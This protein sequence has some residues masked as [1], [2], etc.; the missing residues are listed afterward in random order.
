[1]E[2]QGLGFGKEPSN[3]VYVVAAEPDVREEA[4]NLVRTLRQNRISADMDYM[5]RSMRSQMKAAGHFAEYA[6]IIGPEEVERKTVTLKDLKDGTQEEL[7]LTDVIG[8]LKQ[9]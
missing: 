4:M 7:S 3:K 6:C 1:M 9:K 5:G 2:A 8:K